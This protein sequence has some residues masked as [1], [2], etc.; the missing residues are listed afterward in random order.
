MGF[1]ELRQYKQ[2]LLSNATLQLSIG[3]LSFKK[4]AKD[5]LALNI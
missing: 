2:R 3:N 1:N 4:E 5:P